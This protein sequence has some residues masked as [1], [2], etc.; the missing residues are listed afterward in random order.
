MIF[1]KEKPQLMLIDIQLPALDG[2]HLCRKNSSISI[3]LQR[4]EVQAI[5]RRTIVYIEDT[6]EVTRFNGAIN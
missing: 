5:I 4:L 3:K 1:K 2:F 6:L